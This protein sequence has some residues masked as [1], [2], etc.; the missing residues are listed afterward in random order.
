MICC[1]GRLEDLGGLTLAPAVLVG[2]PLEAH[3]AEARLDLVQIAAIL[4]RHAEEVVSFL[5]AHH[6]AATR[7]W[8][9]RLV[10]ALLLSVLAGVVRGRA[11]RVH[12]RKVALAPLR[13]CGSWR[14]CK[15]SRPHKPLM[16]WRS[17]RLG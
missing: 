17:L 11:R 4:A 8:W 15:V 7:Q 9:R 10:P 13:L 5:Y 3:L 1:G 12:A 16:L 6:S 2:V 14:V